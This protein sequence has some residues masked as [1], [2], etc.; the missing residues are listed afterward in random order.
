MWAREC[1]HV[2]NNMDFGRSQC[3]WSR[4]F[5]LVVVPILAC[6]HDHRAISVDC[7]QMHKVCTRASASTS[8]YFLWSS[9]ED[10]YGGWLVIVNMM[11]VV[12]VVAAESVAIIARMTNMMCSNSCRWWW[13]SGNDLKYLQLLGE[14]WHTRGARILIKIASFH[15]GESLTPTLKKSIHYFHTKHT[16]NRTAE[17]K[18]IPKH[19]RSARS[20]SFVQLK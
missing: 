7:I 15:S 5:K 20:S 16:E 17:K 11:V 10:L 13:L 8:V 6:A 9:L 3:E 2:R 4:T 1:T 19:K 14:L 18:S 12:V